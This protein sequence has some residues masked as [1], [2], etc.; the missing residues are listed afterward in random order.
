MGGSFS[1]PSDEDK[2]IASTLLSHIINAD[3]DGASNLIRTHPDLLSTSLDLDNGLT[4]MHYA[5]VM[6]ATPILSFMI[7]FAT[8]GSR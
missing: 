5:V 2:L 4:A 3:E 1:S 8:M 6:Q 7:S